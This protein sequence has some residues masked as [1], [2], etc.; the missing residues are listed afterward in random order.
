[1][2]QYRALETLSNDD[3]TCPLRQAIA[4]R[5]TRLRPDGSVEDDP[6]D[7]PERSGGTVE[8]E[9]G[10]WVALLLENRFD[11]PLDVTV[12]DLSPAWS[13]EQIHPATGDS[14]SLDP[15]ERVQVPFRVAPVPGLA[16]S[17]DRLKVFVTYD[18]VRFRWLELPALGERQRRI[19]HDERP[20]HP[21]ESQL[22]AWRSAIPLPAVELRDRF[23][24]REWMVFDLML[25]VRAPSISPRPP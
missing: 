11:Q 10:A 24:S 22:S 17:R 18:P 19:S 1:V 4:G 14:R 7:Q 9:A 20:R 8:V 5:L 21:L 6:G 15:G 13:I 16:T 2:A 12:L 3:P 23:T 25:E